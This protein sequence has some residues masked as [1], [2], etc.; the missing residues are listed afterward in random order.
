LSPRDL[1]SMTDDEE[2]GQK[3]P[4][5]VAGRFPA[6]ERG[7]GDRT[8][9]GNLDIEKRFL[10]LTRIDPEQ[11][12]YFYEKYH[13]VIFEYIYWKTEDYELTGDLTGDV[14]LEA[15]E[16]L[17]RFTWQGYSYGA[18]L[19]HI[20]RRVVNKHYR[21]LAHPAENVFETERRENKTQ[22]TPHE[23]AVRKFDM[24][25]VRQCMRILGPDKHDALVLHYWLDLTVREIALVMKTS[26][27]NVKQHLVRGRRQM[28]RWFR[29]HGMD[30]GLSEAGQKMIRDVDAQESGWHLVEDLTG[31][32]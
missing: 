24:Q 21:R 6:G 20:A 27:S 14:F 26:E 8:G 18:W 25:L 16:K 5:L 4:E 32:S 22:P 30:H 17:G 13:D 2:S 9:P 12:R 10:Q 28:L 1:Y 7:F 3:N 23:E 29:D 15:L 11:F 19:F 31:E